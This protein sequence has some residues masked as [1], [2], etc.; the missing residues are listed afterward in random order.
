MYFGIPGSI[1]EK[2]ALFNDLII[3]IYAIRLIQKTHG[4]TPQ[5]THIRGAPAVA[6]PEEPAA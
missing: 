2:W 1:P 3:D 4:R 5:Q 6:V